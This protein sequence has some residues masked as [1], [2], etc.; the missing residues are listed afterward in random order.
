MAEAYKCYL[1]MPYDR[2][3]WDLTS[4]LYSVEGPSYFNISPAGRIGVTDK[5]ATTFTA[6]EN[7]NRYYLM[8]DS[9]QAENIKQHFIQLVS[10]QPANFK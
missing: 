1:E 8:V 9:V 3:T 10:R 6:D 7:G 4:V 2:P 5:G